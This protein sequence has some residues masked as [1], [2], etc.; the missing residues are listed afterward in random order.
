MEWDESKFESTGYNPSGSQLERRRELRNLEVEVRLRTEAFD[1]AV[2]Q[3]AREIARAE[4][5]GTVPTA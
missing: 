3:L 4:R 2:V 1:A 5:E